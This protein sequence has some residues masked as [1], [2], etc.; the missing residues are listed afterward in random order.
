MGQTTAKVLGKTA[1]GMQAIGQVAR[2]NESV[3]DQIGTTVDA[4]VQRFN[5]AGRA[6]R[7]G[8]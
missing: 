1:A 4:I 5:G 7:R 8:R 3:I 2:Q 6:N